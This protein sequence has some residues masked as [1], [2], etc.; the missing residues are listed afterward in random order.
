MERL[1]MRPGIENPFTPTDGN[2]CVGLPNCQYLYGMEGDG[3][4]PT[5]F[6]SGE[7]EWH[8]EAIITNPNPN[9]FDAVR[10]RLKGGSN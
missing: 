2:P 7:G 9:G 8:A 1:P 6:R 4:C 3:R 5:Q 10:Y